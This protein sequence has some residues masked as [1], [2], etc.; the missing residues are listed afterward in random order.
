MKIAG[1]VF[2]VKDPSGQANKGDRQVFHVV[3]AGDFFRVW[4][5][6]V[7]VIFKG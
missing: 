5:L 7:C 4:K 2:H 1:V 3:G 6:E